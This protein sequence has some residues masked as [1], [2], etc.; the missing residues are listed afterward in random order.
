METIKIDGRMGEGGGQILR[1]SLTLAMLFGKTVEIHHVRAGRSK[2]G[3]MRQHLTCVKAAQQISGAHVEGAALGSSQ[4]TFS[5]GAVKAGNYHFDIGSAGS[6]TLVFQTILLPL[7]QCTDTSTVEFIGG[8]HNTG[9]PPLTFIKRSFLPLLR[10]MGGK[11][12]IKAERW[13]FMPVG[14]GR[15][16][17]VIKPSQLM[18][19]HCLERGKLINS[20]VTAYEVGLP[21]RVAE[22]EVKKYQAISPIKVDEYRIRQPAAGSPGNLISH[23]LEFENSRICLTHLGR[24]RISA[25]KVASELASRV[26]DYVNSTAVLEEYLADQIMLPMAVAGGGQVGCGPLS[27]HAETN[28]EVIRQFTGKGF[29]FNNRVLA[30]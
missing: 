29:S 12:E 19:I 25:E 16:N 9:A 1:S 7:L 30:Y 3:L 4:L 28:M 22:R 20:R 13:G 8:T 23:D 5:P 24:L 6:T 17:A 15:W 18:P 10:S 11:V 26:S 2:P 27:Q 21:N 14:G